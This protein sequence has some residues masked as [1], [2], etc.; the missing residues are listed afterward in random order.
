MIWQL[1]FFGLWVVS[2]KQ[3]LNF[4]AEYFLVRSRSNFPP[5]SLI[6]TML[7]LFFPPFFFVVGL[8]LFVSCNFSQ[9]LF[10]SWGGQAVCV[11]RVGVDSFLFPLCFF[12][13]AT[14]DVVLTLHY[15]PL[16]ISPLYF[17]YL[18]MTSSR[19]LFFSFLGPFFGGFQNGP[20]CGESTFV[21]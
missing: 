8:F 12:S 16:L 13:S 17:D 3:R 10:R 20:L 7:L 14:F 9:V 4:V 6:C 2:V 19:Y 21:D 5:L 18:S 1:G 15:R 11:T